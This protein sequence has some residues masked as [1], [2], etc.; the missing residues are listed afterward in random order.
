MAAFAALSMLMVTSCKKDDEDDDTTIPQT[1]GTFSMS[2]EN[3][4]GDNALSLTTPPS[5]NYPYTANGEAFNITS[6]GYYINSIVLEG[7]NGERFEDP[8]NVSANASE[9]K[10]YYQVIEGETASKTITLKDVPSGK[11][12]KVTFKIGISEDG[13]QEGA[14]GGILDPANGAWFWNW[15]AGYIGMA[16]EGYAENSPFQETD[17]GGGV[18]YYDNAFFLHVGG[19]K[20]I[21][22]DSTGVVK[23]VNNVKT[24]TLSLGVD[25]TVDENKEPNA[26]I[27]FDIK[28]VLD[29]GQIDFS[30]TYSVHSPAKGQPFAQ[31]FHH[32][33]S[34]DHVH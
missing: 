10:G 33:F 13:V 8:M 4:V 20:D 9:V 31:H 29:M 26:H 14:A 5:T 22:A 2:F 3:K 6:F 15:N 7:P 27:I 24:I 23:F 28:K 34:V 25:A 17:F 12:N 18:V 21:P 16:M 11:Y 1:Y 32:A 30:T 19:W